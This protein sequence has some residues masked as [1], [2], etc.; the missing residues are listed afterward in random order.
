MYICLCAYVFTCVCE[1][2]MCQPK[3]SEGIF[4]FI[5]NDSVM[6]IGFSLSM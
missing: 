4:H 1:R 5:R 6:K 3:I 2:D